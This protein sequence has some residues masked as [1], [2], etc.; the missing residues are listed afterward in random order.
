MV[1]VKTKP[2]STVKTI[3][4]YDYLKPTKR[5]LQT[6]AFALHIGINDLSLYES[7]KEILEDIIKLAESMKKIK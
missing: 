5:D 7:P 6:D 4:M 3:D 2:F 1:L